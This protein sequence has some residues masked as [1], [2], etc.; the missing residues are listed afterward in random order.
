MCMHTYIHTYIHTYVPRHIQQSSFS[1][2]AEEEEEEAILREAIRDKRTTQRHRFLPF[3]YNREII[4]IDCSQFQ[5]HCLS[6]RKRKSKLKDEI[7]NYISHIL[8]H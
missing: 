2:E 1:A 6:W 4:S 3:N 8:V 5:K 7:V